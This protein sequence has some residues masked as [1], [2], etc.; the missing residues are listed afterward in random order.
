[1]SF[2]TMWTASNGMLALG[3]GMQTISN[4]LANVQT[5]GFKAMRTNYE[6]LISQCYF[7]GG[8][9]NQVGKGSKVGTIQS[10]FTQ[11]AFR[12]S[13][14]D[15]DMAIAGEG[16]FSVRHRQTG[17]IL[18]SRNGSFDFNKEGYLVDQ[19]QNVLQGWQMSIP[20][21]GQS[22]VRIGSPQDIQITTLSAP[23]WPPPA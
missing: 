23:R 18:Y 8:N 19:S 16:F 20:K 12:A 21:A 11:G 14:Q 22:A 3:T 10:M 6:D 7:S 5:V 2:S 9:H 13:E 1:M 17:E 4:N 15:T